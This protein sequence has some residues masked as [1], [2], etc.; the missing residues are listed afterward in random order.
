MTEDRMPAPHT[1]HA[2][3]PSAS[4]A[5]SSSDGSPV[6]VDLDGTLIRT[7]LL[8]ESLAALLRARPLSLLRLPLWLASGKAAFKAR[9]AERAVPDPQ[10]LP[11]REEVLQ[12]LRAQRAAG[13]RVVLASASHEGPVAAVAQHLGLFDAV[14]AS[15]EG[16][17]LSGETKLEAI[18]EETGGG[19]DFAY[20]GNSR[21]DLPIWAVAGEA[22]MVA[23]SASAQREA[24]A[25]GRACTLLVPRTASLCAAIRIMRMHQWVKNIL[26][27][28]PLLLAHQLLDVERLGHVALAFMTFCGVASASYIFN[29]LL[30]A[31]ADR[32]HP[33][34]CDRP[35]AS[36]QLSIPA[37]IL[38]S[39][40]LLFVSLGTS[41]QF[42]SIPSSLMLCG[43]LVLTVAYS[44]YFKQRLFLDVLVLA[45]LYTHRVLA[46]SVAAEVP[47]SPWLLAFST[48]F[49]LSLALAKRYVELT[50]ARESD[51][52]EFLSR[53]AYQ[54]GD[55][56]MVQTM[57]LSAAY[58]S[59]LVLCLFV[60]S[61]DVSRLYS[62][63]EFLWMMCPVMLYWI[64]RVWLLARR[65]E[66]HDDPVVFA[67]SDPTSY[68]SGALIG[69]VVVA[70]TLI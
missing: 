20:L 70:A 49:F 66:L 37:A 64:S 60:S 3:Q 44:T 27:F 34:K 52:H 6:F 2:S 29:D 48:F 58:I 1:A 22:V 41:L 21:A 32:R 40:G 13:R 54:V 35:L 65:C 18:R 42:L 7:D 16:R 56:G 8:W 15:D 62:T 26:F 68:V 30:D 67:F 63:P 45:G 4:L 14:L 17:N 33:T 69:G 25:S 55:I 36:G 46:G 5:Q 11:Y 28:V 24:E 31:E 53:R 12:Y 10:T 51:Q 23:P 39:L 61:E 57:G 19:D 9:L 59:V 50:R 38:L 43:Y 47:V